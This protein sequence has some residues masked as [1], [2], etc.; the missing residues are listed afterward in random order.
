MGGRYTNDLY[1]ILINTKQT[2][3]ELVFFA[4]EYYIYIY[5]YEIDMIKLVEFIGEK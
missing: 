3:N 4:K 5:I 1:V 2:R